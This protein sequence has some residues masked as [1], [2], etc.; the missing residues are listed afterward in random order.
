[1]FTDELIT[2]LSVYYKREISEIK[3]GYKRDYFWVKFKDD[4][5]RIKID[6][7]EILQIIV[8]YMNNLPQIVYIKNN[9][10]EFIPINVITNVK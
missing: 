2:P 7:F 9:K 1:M 3:F 6:S 5:E 8:D 10:S 4:K